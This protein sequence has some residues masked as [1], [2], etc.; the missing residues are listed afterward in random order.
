MSGLLESLLIGVSP[1]AVT[2]F[3]LWVLLV[4]FA[5][6]CLWTRQGKAPRFTAY[7]PTMLTTLGILGT[8]VGIVI[9]LLDFRPTDIDSSIGRLLDGL[10]TAFITSLAGMFTSILYRGL[11]TTPLLAPPGTASVAE[12]GPEEILG[13]MRRHTEMLELLPNLR[14]AIAGAE[15]SSLAGQLKLIRTDFHDARREDRANRTVFEESL[16]SKLDDF[17]EQLSKSATEQVI[18]ALQ[19][20]IVDFNQNLTEQFGENFK[21]LDASVGK[22]VEWQDKYRTQLDELHG[23]YRESAKAAQDSQRAVAGIA[24]SAEA[25]PPTM[26]KL[27]PIIATADR[28]IAELAAHLQAFADMRDRAVEA[29][30][31][32]EALVQEMADKM[33]ASVDAA[34][35][36]YEAMLAQAR[37]TLDSF[38]Q[39][40]HQLTLETQR[41]AGALADSMTQT[42]ESTRAAADEAVRAM[43]ETSQNVQR[44]IQS[45]QERVAESIEL[46]DRRIEAAIASSVEAHGN[47]A[48]TMES[49][50]REQLREALQKTNEGI[51]GH[52]DVLDRAMGDELTRVMNEM[53]G[54]LAQI[55]GKFTQDYQRLVAQMEQVLRAQPAPMNEPRFRSE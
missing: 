18:E 38:A 28:Q 22:L 4:L 35:K 44:E 53:G 32:T 25:I 14:D 41:S 21:A 40:N 55:T 26:E 36:Q 52:F 13:E 16:W 2:E 20:V 31:A 24:E 34:S 51:N 11:T 3:F 46:I 1:R 8:F 37:E 33:A 50:F 27:V 12:A 39:Q 15:E 42:A 7:A 5:L 54:A 6:A 10:K 48:A 49:A 9:G 17:G 29:V 43:A 19:Q 23:L 45:T 47:A 30:P